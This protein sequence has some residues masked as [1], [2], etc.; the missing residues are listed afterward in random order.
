MKNDMLL[1]IVAASL[2]SFTQSRCEK[3]SS[4]GLIFVVIDPDLSKSC[5]DN[6]ATV[7]RNN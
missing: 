1:F 2:N 5:Q 3:A 6:K 4:L 7:D